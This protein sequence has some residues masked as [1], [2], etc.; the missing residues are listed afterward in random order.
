MTVPDIEPLPGLSLRDVMARFT[1]GVTVMTTPGEDGHGMTANA[2][3]SL[4][5]DPP[6]ILC[7]VARDSRMHEAI[8]NAGAFAVSILGAGQ[9]AQARWFAD[10][11]RPGGSAQFAAIAH[12]PGPFSG[13]P[14]LHAASG[15]LDCAIEAVHEGGDHSIVVGAV[16]AAGV[17]EG[18]TASSLLFR[19]GTFHLFE[20]E[21]APVTRAA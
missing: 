8:E 6:L 9:E 5:V 2:F 1:T 16:R 17:D 12:T 7:C 4:S 19:A 15:W 11:A 20:P 13:A 21:P 10:H 18:T 14:V 3:T